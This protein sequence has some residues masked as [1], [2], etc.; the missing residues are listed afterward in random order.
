MKGKLM[1]LLACLFMSASLVTAQTSKVTGLVISAEDGEPVIGATIQVKGAPTLGAITDI[2]GKFVIENLPSSA[3]TLIVSYVGMTT[4]EVTIHP[5]VKVMM[6]S[7]AEVLEEVVIAVPYGTVKK[8][9]FS[10]SAAQV[11]GEKLAEMQVSNISNALQGSIAGI[12]TVSASGTP[13]SGSSIMVRGIG[14]I[15]ADAEPLIV[16]DG[17][18]YSGSLNSIATQDIESLTVL[19]DAAANSMYGARGANGVIMITTKSGGNRRPRVNFEARYGFNQRGIANYDVLTSP[20]EYYEMLHESITNQLSAEMGYMAASQH[21]AANLISGYASYNIYKGVADNAIIDP[22]TGRLT[23]AAKGASLLWNDTWIDG[24]GRGVHQEYNASVSG[25]N[26]YTKAYFSAGYLQDEGIV[27]GSGF[28]RI[29]VRTKVDQKINKRMNLGASLAY[30][31]TD[32][33]VFGSEEGNYSNIFMSALQIAPI[34]PIFKYDANGNPIKDANGNHMYDYGEERI[35]PYYQAGNP[36]ANAQDCINYDVIDNV[37]ARGYFN[38]EIVDNLTFSANIAYDVFGNNIT[39]FMTPVAGDAKDVGGRGYKYATH[40][41]VMNVN[42]LLTWTPSIGRSKF[43]VLVGHENNDWKYSSFSGHMTNFVDKS[44]PEFGNATV[45]QSMT[46]Y[47]YGIAREGYFG[48][49]DFNYDD[50]YYLTSSIRRDASS[51]FAPESRWGTFW[52]VG[53]SWRLSKEAFM[54]GTSSWLQDAKVK[55]SYGTQGNDAIGLY[56]AYVDLYTIERPD[57]A[58]ALTKTQRGNR[59][60]SWEKSAN[61]N[62]GIEGRLFNRFT[63]DANFFIKETKDLLYFSPLPASQG[64][65]ANIWRNEMDMKNTGFDFEITADLYTS[66]NVNVR[67]GL[68]GMTYKN[69]LTKLPDSKD[70]V[71]FPDG[72]RNGSYWR[73]LGG[74][75]YDF[76]LFEY[77]GVDPQTGLPQYNDYSNVYAQEQAKDDNGELLFNEDGT[78]VMVET[79]KV[80]GEKVEIVNTTANLDYDQDARHTKGYSAIPD[81][82]GGL[83]LQVDAYGFDLTVQTAFQL[84]GYVYDSSYASL[85]NSGDAGTNFHKDMLNR[86][87]TPG[88]TTDVP[89]LC[90]MGEQSIYSSASTD[91]WLTSASYFSLKNIS[92]G[93]TLPKSLSKKASIENCRIYLTGDNIWLKSARKGLDPRQ[94]ISGATAFGYS[95]MST[96]SIGVSLTL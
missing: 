58:A 1:M 68:N 28:D 5:Y 93:Y 81:F 46:S 41:E 38:W 85:M 66:K 48:K 82:V 69:Q 74:S 40:K 2:D 18:P 92:L 7:D 11:T 53:G 76:H 31:R 71:N 15:S 35:R 21:A 79:D 60:L 47:N 30:S 6:Q 36:F 72:Y 23:A 89:R 57:G 13:G 75:L 33:T 83:S 59:D 78:P 20:G 61:F 43:N 88:Q 55:A 25:G 51:I 49:V 63:F 10:G 9:N 67:L 29:N 54:S 4:Q 39:E 94:D 16:V 45:Y 19:K 24:I 50:R 44:N 96:Y 64:S 90:Y 95:A 22:V 84:G 87:T 26:D 42:E 70:P 27:P 65:P 32:Q 91:R 73:Q 8:A 80:I 86:W 77:V 37:N 12:Q 56:K 34:Y 3:K 14:S 62:A 17:V 52:A